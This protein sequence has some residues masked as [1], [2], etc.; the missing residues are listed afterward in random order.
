M[1]REEATIVAPCPHH[2]T[3]PLA[4]K[5]DS[6]CNFTQ[7]YDRFSRDVFAK[8]PKE[9][10]MLRSHYSYMIIKKGP[11]VK[12]KSDAKTIHEESFYWDRIVGK[13]GKH[14]RHRTL[15]L[16]TTDGQFEN[17]IIPKSHGLEGGWKW[18]NRCKWGD[19]WPFPRWIPNKYRKTNEKGKRLW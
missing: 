14:G 5:K 11:T 13:I 16:C 4:A 12:S 6:W 9:A 18:A 3:C 19:L 17:R 7:L 15:K 10:M 8:H 2:M 1:S